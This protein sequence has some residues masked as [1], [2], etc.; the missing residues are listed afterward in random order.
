M[1]DEETL[2]LV[3]DGEIEPEDAED[4]EELGDEVKQMVLDGE[5]DIDIAKEING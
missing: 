2:Q 5:I 1:L 3:A 4:F